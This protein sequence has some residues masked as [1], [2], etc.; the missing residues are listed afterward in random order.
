MK[1]PWR[2]Q[3]KSSKPELK[4]SIAPKLPPSLKGLDAESGQGFSQ[5]LSNSWMSTLAVGFKNNLR[6]RSPYVLLLALTLNI[7]NDKTEF[8]CKCCLLIC[9][10]KKKIY[11]TIITNY[12]SKTEQWL[13]WDN[14]KDIGI[15]G[16]VNGHSSVT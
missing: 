10:D 4:V 15:I 8:T 11:K 14:M 9:E 12:I 1:H 6:L 3:S 13:N 7:S 5:W 16:N 2:I